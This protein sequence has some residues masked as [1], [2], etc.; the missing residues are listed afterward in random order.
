[1][2]ATF[3]SAEL[4]A[5]LPSRPGVY[6]FRN[7]AGEVIYVGKAGD[8]K[9]RV[10]SYFQRNLPSPRTAMMVVVEPMSIAIESET[11]SRRPAK[12]KRERLR[13]NESEDIKVRVTSAGREAGVR[14]R[15]PEAR[16]KSRPS[17]SGFWLPTPDSSPSVRTHH[18]SLLFPTPPE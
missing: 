3:D 8:L 7:A 16:I 6:R 9:K 15:K 18:R 10:S 4:I 11:R 2:T 1:M 13:M 17:S 5:G 14:S 12:L